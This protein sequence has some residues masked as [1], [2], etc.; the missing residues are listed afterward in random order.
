MRVRIYVSH[1]ARGRSQSPRNDL[2]VC[3]NKTVGLVVRE[4]RIN[5]LHE[6]LGARSEYIYHSG[7]R[8][9]CIGETNKA[10][11]QLQKIHAVLALP[12]PTPRSPLTYQSHVQAPTKQPNPRKE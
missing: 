7:V 1:G 4:Y 11:L 8:N 2:L 12:L 3:M 6:H 5:D 10:R 9:I